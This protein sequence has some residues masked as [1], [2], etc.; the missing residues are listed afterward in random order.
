MI[1]KQ[2]I[3]SNDLYALLEKQNYRCALTGR[4]LTPEITDAEHIV[5]LDAGGE[6]TP[7]NIYLIIKDAARLKRYLSEPD[8]MQLC[9]DILNNRGK[10]Y[11]YNAT[12]V[13]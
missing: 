1:K 9:L 10:H 6:H 7:D 12:R 11:G 2:T 4:E 13:P 5:P 8:L 3:R